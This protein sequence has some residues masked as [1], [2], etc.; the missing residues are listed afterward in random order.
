MP[1]YEIK[2]KKK[3]MFD[4]KMKIINFIYEYKIEKNELH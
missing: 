1:S 4:Y 3:I 2:K